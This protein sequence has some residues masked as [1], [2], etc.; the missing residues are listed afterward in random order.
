MH[1]RATADDAGPEL[2]EFGQALGRLFDA[3]RAERTLPYSDA[4]QVS[5]AD[6]LLV[7]KVVAAVLTSAADRLR[8]EV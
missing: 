2:T 7:L 1:D 5:Q 6:L 3:A 8:R 4:V